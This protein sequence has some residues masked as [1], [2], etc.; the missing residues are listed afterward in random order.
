MTELRVG[1]IGAG[2]WGR[3]YIHTLSGIS[4]VRLVR[5]AS[6]N[7]ESASLVGPNCLVSTDWREVATDSTL[8]GLVIAT[9]P[10]CHVEMA[11][12]ALRAGLHVLVEKPMT[13]FAGEA[14]RLVEASRASRRMVFVGH[15]HLFSN[16]FRGLKAMGSKLGELREV[17]SSAGNW[18]PD[19]TDASV[20]WD[21]A[22]H[23]L[24]MCLDLIGSDP[25]L[26]GARQTGTAMLPDGSGES[27]AI[28]LEFGEATKAAI[29][30]SNIDREK[31]RRFEGRF[32][33]G[34]LIYDDLAAVKLCFIPTASSV[35][36]ELPIGKSLPL[37]NLL[38]EFAAEI[39]AGSIWH[40][41][42]DIGVRVVNLMA[43]CQHS[44][45]T[46]SS[47]VKEKGV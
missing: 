34:V 3:R 45:D 38:N 4:G 32:D 31:S 11:E 9:P 37:D 29:V 43:A 1:L 23:D 40:A 2:R 13:L 46:D 10:A 44:L 6:G 18:G 20:L 15:T 47:V 33:E 12:T 19:R 41:S 30:V 22:P 26:I 28:T 21:W 42:L 35:S 36:Q 27:I 17:R 14:Q 8:D 25:T 24:A 5:L 7:P 39:R 16:A